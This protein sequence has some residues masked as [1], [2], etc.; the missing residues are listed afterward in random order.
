MPCRGPTLVPAP[1]SHP[2]AHRGLSP[3]QTK[4]RLQSKNSIPTLDQFVERRDYAGALALLE[5]KRKAGDDSVEDV[6]AWIAYCATRIGEYDRALV[7]LERAH[8]AGDMGDEALT[9]M[10]ICHLYLHDYDAASKCAAGA[11]PSAL[12]NRLQFITAVRRNDEE[13]FFRYHERL[14]EGPVDKLCLASAMDL[15]RKHQAVRSLRREAS[16]SGQ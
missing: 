16:G 12:R 4:Q 13:R 5:F 7:A 10:G 6:D 8:G 11:P 15:R 14:E 9:Y 2:A 3:P 1:V